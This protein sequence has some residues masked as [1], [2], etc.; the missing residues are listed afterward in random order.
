M[1]LKL[2]NDPIAED[3]HDLL[4]ENYDLQLT[5]GVE[6]IQQALIIRL[7]FFI[8]EWFL[9]ITRGVEFYQTIYV[10]NPNL[11]LVASVIKTQILTTPGVN[12]ILSYAQ[13][14]DSTGRELTVVFK[15]DTDFGELEINEA[16]VGA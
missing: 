11:N 13:S 15:V 16:L 3:N 14:F 9:D 6:A 1:D 5:E 10:K 7:Q 2:V 12:E 4:I 8:N